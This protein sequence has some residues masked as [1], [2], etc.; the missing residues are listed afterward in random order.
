METYDSSAEVHL[1]EGKMSVAVDPRGT[2]LDIEQTV[3][4]A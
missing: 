1:L 3:D 2:A 4:M